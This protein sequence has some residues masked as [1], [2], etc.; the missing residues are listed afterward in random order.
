MSVLFKQFDKLRKIVYSTVIPIY[1]DH[2][3]K[4]EINFTDYVKLG[5]FDA[6]LPPDL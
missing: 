2:M 4:S 5:I 6:P 1:H 3:V